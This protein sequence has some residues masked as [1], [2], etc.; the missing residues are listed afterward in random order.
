MMPLHH[1]RLRGDFRWGTQ[2]G[3]VLHALF[4]GVPSLE[5]SVLSLECAHPSIAQCRNWPH[6]GLNRGPCGY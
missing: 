3:N 2:V 1:V 5:R 6:A 4:R